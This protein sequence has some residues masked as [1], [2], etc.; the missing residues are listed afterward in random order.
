M[1]IQFTNGMSI[2]PKGTGGGNTGGAGWYFYSD[3]GTLNAGPPIDNGNTIFLDGLGGDETFDP[4]QNGVSNLQIMFNVFNS[5]GTNFGGDFSSVTGNGGVVTITQGSNVAEYF[6]INGDGMSITNFGGF[7]VFI[8]DTTN[9]IQTQTA[10]NP[11]NANDVIT[12]SF[13]SGG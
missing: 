8:I 3:E 5:V 1:A 2:T 11:F 4:N 9:C 6:N 10:A 12:L 13:S 7:D